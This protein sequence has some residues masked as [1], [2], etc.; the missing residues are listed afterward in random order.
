MALS[1][2][3]FKALFKKRQEQFLQEHGRIALLSALDTVALVKRRVINERENAD[4]GIFGIYS[5]GYQKRRIDN[6]L[7]GEQINFSFTNKMWNSTTARI[8]ENTG[9]RV[10]VFISPDADNIEKLKYMTEKFGPILVLNPE[11]EQ[12]HKEIY[13]NKVKDI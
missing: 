13:E 4:G 7:L 6:N 12:I 9:D 2:Q 5:A 10:V 1:P 8:I 11:E 3:Q